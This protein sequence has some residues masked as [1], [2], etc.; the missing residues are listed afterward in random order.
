MFQSL[1]ALGTETAGSGCGCD[2]E[3][4]AALAERP[5]STAVG[6]VDPG[7]PAGGGMGA[8]QEGPADPELPRGQGSPCRVS[9][10]ER[11]EA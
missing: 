2:S 8:T 7:G 6:P 11:G 10:W 3:P 9:A 1:E 4:Q 5:P